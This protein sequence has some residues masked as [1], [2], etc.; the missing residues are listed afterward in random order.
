MA[1]ERPYPILVTAL[2]NS[3]IIFNISQLFLV[4]NILHDGVQ[5]TALYL[6]HLVINHETKAPVLQCILVKGTVKEIYNK[7]DDVL[8][9]S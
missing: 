5:T 6:K 9:N 2:D 8:R 7:I 3:S 4:E 1:N